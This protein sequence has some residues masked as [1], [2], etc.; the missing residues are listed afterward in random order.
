M[1]LSPPVPA[2]AAVRYKAVALLFIVDRIVCRGAV[3]GSY[4]V[5]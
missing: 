1:D 5:M 3:F 2:K 4:F